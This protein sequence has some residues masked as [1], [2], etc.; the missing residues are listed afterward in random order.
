MDPA[1][2]GQT[3][4]LVLGKHSGRAAFADALTK[5]GYDLGDDEFQR[6][7]ARFKELADRKGEI[8]EEGLRAIVS[9][10]TDTID[11]D[12]KLISLHVAGGSHEAP[13]ATV[14]L[15]NAG[16]ELTSSADGDGMVNA[17]FVALQDAYGIP[18]TLADYRVSPLEAGA[19]AMAKV[20]VIIQVGSATFSGR[21][22]STDVVEGSARAMVSALNKA[23]AARGQTEP[24]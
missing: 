7:F 2:V 21:G 13:V 16:D 8:S 11:T 19:D 17:A 20:D 10:E 1:A 3:S 23:S 5:L 24:T 22:V 14:I 4:T 18:A 6:C 15:D 9:E 12:M